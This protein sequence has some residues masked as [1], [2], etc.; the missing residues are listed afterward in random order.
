MLNQ[1]RLRTNRSSWA[2]V[3]TDTSFKPKKGYVEIITKRDSA[4]F[5]EIINH[6]ILPNSI[7]FTDKWNAYKNI[8]NNNYTHKTVNH[9]YH[10]VDPRTGVHMQNVESY[11]NKLKYKMSKGIQNNGESIF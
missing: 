5:L 10:F 4:T 2:I 3:I 9:K 1:Q 11:N 7:I 8:S 6:I